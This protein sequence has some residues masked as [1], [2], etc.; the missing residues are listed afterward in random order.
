MYPGK[1]PPTTNC[2]IFMLGT[3]FL[4]IL[5]RFWISKGYRNQPCG[6]YSIFHLTETTMNYFCIISYLLLVSI[7]WHNICHSVHLLLL[8]NQNLCKVWFPT[9][10]GRL[11]W[12]WVSIGHFMDENCPQNIHFR[13]IKSDSIP[14]IP[15]LYGVLLKIYYF[16][17]P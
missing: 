13:C 3:I 7:W 11:E 17:I 2:N 8:M 10:L 12:I 6:R 15:K 1:P 9:I 4:E 16:S 14:L 5:C